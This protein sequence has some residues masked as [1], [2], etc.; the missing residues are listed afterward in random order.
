EVRA[1]RRA[2]RRRDGRRRGVPRRLAPR[3][4]RATR[5]RRTD[6][7]AARLGRDSCARGRSRGAPRDLPRH[8][9]RMA[10]LPAPRLPRRRHVGVPVLAQLPASGD[11][12]LALPALEL[13]ARRY[14]P[15]LIMAAPKYVIRPFQPGDEEG[16]LAT[17]NAVFGENDPAFVPRTREEWDWA[18][19]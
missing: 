11:H 2:A 9:A 3:L 14:A 15:P 19:A 12:E 5:R 16:I 13:H 4:D 1:R 6:P 17:F 10:A 18:F 8:R 7:R